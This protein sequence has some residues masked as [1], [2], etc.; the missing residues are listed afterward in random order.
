MA[1][2]LMSLALEEAEAETAPTA[3][4]DAKFGR[5]LGTKEAACIGRSFFNLEE[6]AKSGGG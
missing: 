3:E 4:G 2:P 5:A 1:K 6:N